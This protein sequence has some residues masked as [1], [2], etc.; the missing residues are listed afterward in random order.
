MRTTQIKVVIIDSTSRREGTLSIHTATESKAIIDRLLFSKLHTAM[1]ATS[2]PKTG[3]K[4]VE[5]FARH[6]LFHLGCE[7][8][9]MKVSIDLVKRKV[10]IK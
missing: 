3:M 2:E 10:R 8:Y 5:Y 1:V 4:L 7:Q 9:D 6:E